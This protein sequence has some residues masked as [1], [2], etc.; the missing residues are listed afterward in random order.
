M[1]QHAKKFTVHDCRMIFDDSGAV[2]QVEM[3]ITEKV[4]Y[5]F[6]L[7]RI[8]TAVIYRKKYNNRSGLGIFKI[9][10]KEKTCR[11]IFPLIF[12]ARRILTHFQNNKDFHVTTYSTLRHSS[13][14]RSLVL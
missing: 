8:S 10:H 12:S 9:V 6:D 7:P 14:A 2:F 11:V 1:S 5:L 13:L 4:T 3:L